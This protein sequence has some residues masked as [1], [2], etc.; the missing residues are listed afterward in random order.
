MNTRE[1]CLTISFRLLDKLRGIR[2]PL[3]P[4]SS[5]PLT[6]EHLGVGETDEKL[7]ATS[8]VSGA[9]GTPI[10]GDTEARDPIDQNSAK[11]YSHL[12]EVEKAEE[13]GLDPTDI[14]LCIAE[15]EQAQSGTTPK[16]ATLPFRTKVCV[17]LSSFLTM[18]L[19]WNREDPSSFIQDC[20]D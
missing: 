18:Y 16:S 17:L 14:D 19:N 11:L 1:I 12:E 20:H 10:D 3:P 6:S 8:D 13:D 5:F 4:I 9:N 15:I 2:R 7:S